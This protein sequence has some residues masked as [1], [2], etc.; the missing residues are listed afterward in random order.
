MDEVIVSS[1]EQII[2][3]FQQQKPDTFLLI[4]YADLMYCHAFLYIIQ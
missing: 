3:K 1:I 4:D 2:K